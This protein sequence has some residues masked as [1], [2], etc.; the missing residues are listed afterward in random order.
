[1]SK[2]VIGAL[3][4]FAMLF[5]LLCVNVGASGE[6]FT[7]VSEKAW[8]APAVEYAVKNGLMNGVGNNKFEPETAMS[9]A[10]LVTVL[11]RYAGQ[12]KEGKNTFRDVP[13]GQWYTD[14]VAWAAKNGVVN[15]VGDNQFE[16]EGKITRE[17]MA[18]ILFRY[19]NQIDVDT[20]KRS[21]L[22]GF[23]DYKQV[24]EYALAPM[25]WAVAERIINGSDGCLLPNGDATR[26]QVAAILMRFIQKIAAAQDTEYK[27]ALITDYG[28]ITDESYNQTSWDGIR[29]WCYAQGIECTYFK[30][31]EDSTIARVAAIDCAVEYGYNILV[32]P[33]YMMPDSVRETA[34]KY[35]QVKFIVLD[36]EELDFYNWVTN[37]PYQLPNNVV[38]FNYRE[39]LSGYMAGYA[40]V[41]LGYTHLGFLGGMAVPAVVHYGYGFVQGANQAAMELGITDKVK[42]EYIYGNQFY[43]DAD[44]T[45]CMDSWYQNKGV[46]VVFACGGGI[47]LS[48]GEAAVKVNGKVIGVDVDQAPTIDGI[49]GSGMTLT[50]AAKG[51]KATISMILSEIILNDRWG[52]YGGKSVR[53]GLTSAENP[54]LN[55]VQLPNSTQL[56]NGKFS[57]EDYKALI[58]K[59]LSGKLVVSDNTDEPPTVIITVNYLGNIK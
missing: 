13:D 1:M 32:L 27:V 3:L 4:V 50:S 11:W 23:V 21:D 36:C 2:K 29:S 43:S 12:P 26:A 58:A 56:V 35:P 30:P 10:M 8:Y 48:A 22:K 28:D 38:T 34:G 44:I 25:R 51:L 19:A 41:K 6:Q 31:S 54:E 5:S 40:A 59:I 14:A 24:S 57:K 20:G 7:D 37:T 49:F 46:E 9:R 53:L 17:Q 18:T 15:G 45:A 47:F 42:I 55:Y 52:N 33:G 39:E 16:P